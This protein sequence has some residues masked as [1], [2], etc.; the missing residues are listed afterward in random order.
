M[1]LDYLIKNADC[2]LFV[3]DI[4]NEETFNLFDS[5]YRSLIEEYKKS[6]ILIAFCGNKTDLEE[7]RKVSFEKALEFCIENEF[8]F[9]E[10]SC[11]TMKNVNN[12]FETLIYLT[13]QSIKKRDKKNND[14]FNEKIR[15]LI[16]KNYNWFSL[17]KKKLKIIS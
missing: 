11:I 2:I 9:M 13:L 12:I 15:N 6:N 1:N 4:T 17:S 7:E 10:T 16:K 5:R 3:Y 14:I 8:F